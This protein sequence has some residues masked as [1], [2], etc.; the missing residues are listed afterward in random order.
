M[1][2]FTRVLRN[3]AAAVLLLLPLFAMAAP[4]VV[5]NIQGPITPASAD[6]IER[7]LQH[8]A[9]EGALLVILQLDTPGGLDTSMRQ[10]VRDIVASPVPVAGFV[11]PGG[12]RAA[13][14]G[15][16]ILYATHIAAMAPGTNLGAATPVQIGG[17]PDSEP[18]PKTKPRPPPGS[19]EP[20]PDE[21]RDQNVAKDDNMSTKNAMSRKAIHDAAAYIR[22]LAQMRGRN[23]E[24]AERAVREA[25]SLSASEALNLK[26]I[27]YVATD[28][29]DLL[30][31]VNGRRMTIL[32]QNLTLDTGSATL[33]IVEPD[34]RTRALAVITNPSVAYVLMLIGIY[35]L[36]FEFSN[37]G[38]VLPGVAGA[39]CLLLAMYAFQLLPVSYAGLALILLGMAFM[40]AEAFLP[41]FGALGIGGIIAFIA[42][43]VMLIDIDM[44]GYGIPWPMIAATSL[45][46]ASFLVFVIGMA[47]KSRRAPIVSGREELF[48]AVG[49]VLEDTPGEG[50]ARIRGELWSVRCTQPLVRG[51]KVR[52]TGIDGLVLQVDPVEK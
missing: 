31:Q 48:G 20:K 16:Y 9:A 42:G 34:W 37:P 43:S 8:A 12:A 18:E 38:F 6:F 2:L 1:K 10:I 45:A 15:T 51:Q 27:D 5:L 40:V 22:G 3:S 28:V 52:V 50:M 49:E 21:G 25:V 41:S 44:P 47:L 39:I 24:W 11:A 4:V 35:G 32:G 26:V 33:E 14:A 19:P 30:E 46:S 36:F 13:S 23:A 7:G 17:L 29:P